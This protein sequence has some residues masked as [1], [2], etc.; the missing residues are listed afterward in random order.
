MAAK[1]ISR[2]EARARGFKR[3]FTGKACLRGHIAERA[4]VNC[5]CLRCAADKQIIW[6]KH[7]PEKYRE[8]DLIQRQSERRKHIR[9]KNYLKFQERL[10]ERSAIRRRTK[11]EAVVAANKRWRHKNIEKCRAYAKINSAEWR[12]NNPEARKIITK[13]W[14]DLHPE[15]GLKQLRKRRA[16]KAGAS[17]SHTQE[18]LIEILKLQ[19]NRCGHCRAKFGEIIKPTLDHII[20]LSR[21]G[22]HNRRNLQFLC[23]RCNSAKNNLDPIDFARKTGMLL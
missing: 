1:I 15:N 12:Q 9:R 8:R 4:V 2:A 22:T 6:R 3:Y 7:N 18:D 5:I 13:R 16:R 23:K 19:K 11:P 17:G 14:R 21:N 10:K 20:A